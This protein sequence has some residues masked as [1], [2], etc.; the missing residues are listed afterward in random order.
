MAEDGIR[1]GE[2]VPTSYLGSDPPACGEN[3]GLMTDAYIVFE[4]RQAWH[5]AHSDVS[6]VSNLWGM[7]Q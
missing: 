1:A 6:D 7:T 5:E 3:S 4:C 2:N